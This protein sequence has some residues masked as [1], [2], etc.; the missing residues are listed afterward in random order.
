MGKGIRFLLGSAEEFRVVQRYLTEAMEQDKSLSWYCYS[1]ESKLP[2][3]KRLTIEAWRGNK[4]PPQCHRCQAFGHAS[5]NCYRTQKC[6]R[7]AGEH[8]ARDCPRPLTEPPTCANCGKPHTTKDRRCPAFKKEARCRG[9][10]IASQRPKAPETN[11]EG[12]R[13]TKQKP[14]PPK[15]QKLPTQAQKRPA[16]IPVTTS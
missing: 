2:T 15:L 7:C 14:P 10:K 5:S 11:K 12:T 16:T 8:L 13:S 9:I 4:A 6:V 1:P 3:K